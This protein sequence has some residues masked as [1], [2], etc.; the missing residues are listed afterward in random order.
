MPTRLKVLSLAAALGGIAIHLV[1][2][3]AVHLHGPAANAPLWIGIAVGGFPFL[4]DLLK[5][6][7]H[8]QFGADLLAGIAVVTAVVMGQ[9]IV[10]S[11]VV[12][13][14]AGGQVLE[15]LATA[16]ASSVLR[17][18]A[19]RTPSVAHRRIADHVEDIPVA[20]IRVGD[21]LVVYPH[22]TCPVDGS[23]VAGISTMDESFLTGEPFQVRKTTGSAVI[24]GALNGEAVL[25]ITAEKLSQDSRYARIVAVIAQAETSP[26][27]IRRLGDQLG[28]IYTPLAVALALLVWLLSHDSTR[29]LSVLVIATPCPLLLAIPTALIGSMSLAAKRS[30][31]IRKP[32]VLEQLDHIRTMLFDKT[33]TLTYGQPVVT[34][35]IRLGTLSE[36]D[37]VRLTATLEQYSKH[38]LSGAVLT[39]AATRHLA[40]QD[41]SAIR[42]KPGEGL[43]GELDGRLLRITGR[44][45][46]P[47]SL[48]ARLPAPTSGMEC[49]LMVDEQL[50]GLIRFH[51]QPRPEGRS[52]IHHLGPR[53]QVRRLMILS[54]DRSSEVEYLARIVGIADIRSGLNPEEKL[55][56]VR[57]ETERAPTM[58]LGDGINDAPAMLAATVGIAFGAGSDVTA[59]AASAI[60][61]E[62]SLTRVDELLHI[63]RRFRRIALQSAAG[64]MALSAAGMLAAAFGWLPPLWGAIGQE[65]ID[66]LAIL[67]ALR[68]SLPTKDLRDFE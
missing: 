51:D 5:K 60:V 43:V 18:L 63:G 21:T 6:F 4:L 31:V 55:A 37:V 19:R 68:A 45:K 12:V 53:H 50:A 28:A 32:A 41:A 65:V 36:E 2:A 34:E 30:I 59:E 17:A 52:F 3:F 66:V 44:S 58:F 54:G 62:A 39:A 33:G 40:L 64:G 14:L 13:M 49:V 20:D 24:S 48:A 22:E 25:T 27:P 8:R 42:E 16:R 38:P 11:I 23:V 26:P 10:A 67:N 56:I 46:L 57:E 35:I 15:D 47:A 1:L 29:F 61:L 9:F 7:L